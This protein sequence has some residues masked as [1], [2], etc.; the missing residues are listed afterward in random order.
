MFLENWECTTLSTCSTASLI[1]K[2]EDVFLQISCIKISQTREQPIQYSQI[3]YLQPYTGIP[4]ERC[5][6][7][8]PSVSAIQPRPASCRSQ[9][10][11]R[12]H[13][14]LIASPS[15]FSQT[16]NQL[17]IFLDEVLQEVSKCSHA[18]CGTNCLLN[19]R[20][21]ASQLLLFERQTLPTQYVPLYLWNESWADWGM[22]RSL[23]WEQWG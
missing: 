16:L 6:P 14:T 19:Q 22:L 17:F 18:C 21:E 11:F 15:I 3:L 7:C 23:E 10:R 8:Q 4:L 9:R 5:Y 20:G 13:S 12:L 2:I 1:S